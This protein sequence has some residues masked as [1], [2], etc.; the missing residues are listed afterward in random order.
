M[1]TMTTINELYQQLHPESLKL[2]QEAQG[3]FPDGV[4]HD[5]RYMMPFPIY[6]THAEGPHKW[7]VDG[8]RYVDYVMGHGSLLLGHSHPAIVEAV[9]AQ[10]SKGT[11]LGASH[12]TEIRWAQL[13]TKLVPSADK[14][15]FTS[16]GT[17]AT[18]MALRL[19]R[20]HTG[21]SK[22]IKFKDHFHG[23]HDYVVAGVS[24][25]AGVPDATLRTMIVLEANDI[26]LVDRTLSGDTD[27]AAVILEPTGAHMGML[28][29]Q[30][31][32]LNDLRDVTQRHGVVLIFDEVVTGFRTSPGGAQGRYGVTPD[33]TTMA[34]IL[35]GGLPA[36]GVAGRADI[37][38]MI[39]HT[40]EPDWDGSR[41]VAHPGT[42]NGNPVSASAG[43][44]ALELVATTGVNARADAMAQRLKDGLNRLLATMEIP[45]CANGVASLVH[46]TLGVQH[47]CDGG[48][49]S[50]AAEQI[51]AAMTP[52]RSSALKRALINAGVDPM[53]GRGCIVSATHTEQD[54]DHTV[55][56]YEEALTA[57]RNEGII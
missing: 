26:S 14:V 51:N 22:V 9:T 48:I 30:P 52:Q 2:F 35:G 29:I 6:A 36:G 53:G 12:E 23:W 11:H 19:A 15:R 33:L 40:G 41:R 21:K 31:S 47:E 57:I 39:Q 49:C 18:L 55:E 5:T 25:V 54:I 7:D 46:V 3:L 4:T 50:L 28:P 17:E 45:G 34:K 42:F 32:F 38:D 20:A 1:Y 27:I 24:S 37:M 16:S 13:V 56:A 10:M 44:A 8:N 43:V